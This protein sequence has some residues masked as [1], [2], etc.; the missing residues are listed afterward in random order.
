[1]H[2]GTINSSYVAGKSHSEIHG[3]R[4]QAWISCG[5]YFTYSKKNKQADCVCCGNQINSEMAEKV[6]NYTGGDSW[7]HYVSGTCKPLEERFGNYWMNMINIILKGDY[8]P[9]QEFDVKSDPVVKLKFLVDPNN[10]SLGKYR[11]N[12][13]DKRFPEVVTNN[14]LYLWSVH[15]YRTERDA[16]LK[17][18]GV[19]QQIKTKAKVRNQRRKD[20][21]TQKDKTL[22]LG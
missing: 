22:D 16:G 7:L 5:G 17:V 2:F 21:Q 18:K 1:M 10:V 11:L 20:F 13:L 19:I 15:K 14:R 8:H 9:I 3:A 6:E 12:C 4:I